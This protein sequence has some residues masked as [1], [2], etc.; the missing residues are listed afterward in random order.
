[1]GRRQLCIQYGM[2]K[3]EVSLMPTTRISERARNTLRLLSSKT[4]IPMQ[5]LLER[6][7]ESYRRQRFLEE[8]NDAFSALKDDRDEWQEEQREREHWDSTMA[9]DLEERI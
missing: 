3:E 8:S 4:N 5:E 2:L 1:M 9:D 7:I 6:A